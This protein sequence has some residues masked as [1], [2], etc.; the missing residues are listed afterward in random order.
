MLDAIPVVFL[1]LGG[2]FE[3]VDVLGRDD[4]FEDGV[5]NV[6]KLVCVFHVFDG[7]F[8]RVGCHGMP[9]CLWL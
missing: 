6:C 4:F 8:K 9:C 5:G 3:F 2:D 7:V 1:A